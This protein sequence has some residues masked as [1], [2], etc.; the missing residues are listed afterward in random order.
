[1]KV[2]VVTDDG[3]TISQHFG[4][5]TYYEVLTVE[6]GSVTGRERR[7]KPAHQ[8]HHHPAHDLEQGVVHLHEDGDAEATGVGTG[9][10]HNSVIAS[11]QDCATVISRGMGLGAYDSLRGAGIEP[12]I[13]DVRE[14]DEAV[15][16]YLAGDLVDHPER[17][18]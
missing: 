8:H 10:A 16:Q 5:A 18:H 15:R 12:I 2:A 3:R 13:T 6:N 14:I 11:I 17:L 7:E 1:M 9:N 4:R